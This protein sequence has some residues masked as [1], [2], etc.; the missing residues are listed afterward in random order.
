MWAIDL[1][2]RSCDVAVYMQHAACSS[3]QG[4]VGSAAAEVCG[5]GV[6]WFSIDERFWWQQAVSIHQTP[7]GE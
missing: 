1:F 7:D 4:L 3:P 2:G 6:L 5:M